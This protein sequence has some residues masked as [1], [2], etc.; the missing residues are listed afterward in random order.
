MG[1]GVAVLALCAIALF[2]WFPADIKGGFIER[3]LAG[4][5]VPGDAFF[6]VLLAATLAALA[7]VQVL[8][9]LLRRG[10][11]APGAGTGP[12]TGRLTAANLR[13]LAVFHLLVLA[14]IA[15]MYWL[16]PATVAA[17]KATGVLEV[18]YR[19]LSDTAPYKYLGYLAGGFLMTTG[20]IAFAE[21]RLR[22]RALLTVAVVLALTVLLFDVALNNVQLPPNADQ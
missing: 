10:A 5:P 8:L 20:L 7:A 11:R 22:R 2:A 16:G 21:G 9:A 1:F 18:D 3:S 13:F 4:K 12:D 14:G 19:Q 17:L 15:L 6:P